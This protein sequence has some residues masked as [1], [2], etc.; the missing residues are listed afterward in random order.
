MES[1]PTYPQPYCLV[2]SGGGARG[3]YHIG[4]WRALRELNVPVNAF[5]GNSIGAIISAFHAQGLHE[6][7]EAIGDT[8]GIETIIKV[9]EGLVKDGGFHIDRSR[10]SAFREFSKSVMGR[11]GIDTSPMRDLIYRTLD[12]DKIRNS[13]VDLGVVTFN[14]TDLKPREVFIERMEPGK[15]KV[16]VLASAAFP[17]FDRPVI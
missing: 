10:L 12:E 11:R 9:P 17:G 14:L 7:L 4:V 5:I 6:E 2:L 1:H 8:I 16:Y 13:G 3:M 15:L